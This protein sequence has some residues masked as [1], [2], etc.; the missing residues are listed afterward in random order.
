MSELTRL[1]IAEA[2]KK[3]LA[4]EF[5]AV[6]LTNAYLDAIDVAAHEIPRPRKAALFPPRQLVND[7]QT[8]SRLGLNTMFWAF[9]YASHT[10]PVTRRP[11]VGWL[12]ELRPPEPLSVC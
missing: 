10:P 4:K 1:T 6:E 12:A 7:F 9:L 2:R 3:L 8:A 5:S 11:C